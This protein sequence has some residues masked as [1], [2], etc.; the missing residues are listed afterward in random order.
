MTIRVYNTATQ[1]REVFEPLAP[2]HVRLYVCGPTVYDFAHIGNAR[3]V[4]VFDVLVRLLRRHYAKVTYVRNITD[5]EDKINDAARAEGVAIDVITGR[6]T[7]AYHQDMAAL[8]ALPPDVE[9]RATD[10]VAEMIEMIET[11]IA[12]GHAYEA[13]GHVLFSV[14]S[15]PD[16]GAFARRSPDE[17]MAGARIEV[18]PYKR[19]PMDFVLWKPSDAETPGWDSPW[20]RGRPGWHIECSAMGK[21]YLGVTF[22]IHGGGLDLVFPHHQNEIAQSHCAH[23]GAPLAKYWMHNGYVVVEGEKMSKS[24]GNF[25][26]VRELLEEGHPGEAIRLALLAAHYR[27]PLDFTREGLARAR[28]TL[29]RWYRAVAE[30]DAVAELP[31]GVMAALEDDLNTPLAITEMHKLADAALGGDAVAAAALKAAG[32]VMGLLEETAS[33]WFQGDDGGGLSAEAIEAQIA[34]RSKARKNKDFQASDKIRDELLDQ[35][36]ILEDKPDGTTEW[37]R[38]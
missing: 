33:D 29:D 17:M 15:M 10:H 13:E 8:G 6:T 34:T 18:A 5:I 32:T 23:D 7:E 19:D 16:Y 27:Q 35:G 28:Q 1:A 22:D 36:V 24:L 12:K 11:L 31:E 4:V 30:A 25:F 2:E 37:R 20:G 26:T 21:S 14:P 3:P 9:P 38:A